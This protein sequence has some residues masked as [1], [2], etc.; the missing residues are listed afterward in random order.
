MLSEKN[1]PKKQSW[2]KRCRY[3]SKRVSAVRDVWK[4]SR[5]KQTNLSDMGFRLGMLPKRIY[6]ICCICTFYK[7]CIRIVRFSRQSRKK[8]AQY[9]LLH[10]CWHNLYKAFL[11]LIENVCIWGKWSYGR[12]TY[13]FVCNF[14]NSVYTSY[15]YPPNEYFFLAISEKEKS[16]RK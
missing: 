2:D 15:C 7:K 4:E 6:T 13:V 11:I 10:S 5:R 9:V 12:L 8:E 3:S 16:M 1:P 14:Y